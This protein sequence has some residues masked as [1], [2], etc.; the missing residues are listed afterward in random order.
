MISFALIT[1]KINTEEGEFF[2]YGIKCNYG[3]EIFSIEDITVDKV[4][5]DF[6]LKNF[7]DGHPSR[8]HIH[9]IIENYLLDFADF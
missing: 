7:N 6:I 1:K 5:I 3:D 4:K 9:D 2:S 8:V